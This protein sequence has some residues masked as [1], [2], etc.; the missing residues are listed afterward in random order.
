MMYRVKYNN[1]VGFVEGNNDSLTVIASSNEDDS[2]P[3]HGDNLPN[4]NGEP[5]IILNDDKMSLNE[6]IIICIVVA[7]FSSLTAFVTILLLNKKKEK[8]NV[9]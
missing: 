1:Q 3:N 5:D 4:D 8:K 9:I 6:V 2:L 7:V